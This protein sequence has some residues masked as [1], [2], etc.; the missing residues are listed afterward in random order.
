MSLTFKWSEAIERD[1]IEKSLP[2][3]GKSPEQTKRI[4]QDLH[5]AVP[6]W[7]AKPGLRAFAK[8]SEV[9]EVPD[10]DD[11][12]VLAAAIAA[13]V[14]VIVT[15]NLID[16]SL[17]MVQRTGITIEHSSAVLNAINRVFPYEMS[18]AMRAVGAWQPPYQHHRVP[19]LSESIANQQS[20]QYPERHALTGQLF[21]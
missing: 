6:G 5:T 3:Q 14:D 4:I 19:L 10:R 16:F 1:L 11:L 20:A 13:D 12:E 9:I 2:N 17:E 21:V 8:T 7:E 15:K 18:V